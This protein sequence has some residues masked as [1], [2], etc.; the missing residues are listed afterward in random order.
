MVL[1]SRVIRIRKN[2]TIII[3]TVFENIYHQYHLNDLSTK[4][5]NC[6]IGCWRIKYKVAHAVL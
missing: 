1:Q 3:I 5:K 6:D 4:N 2:P